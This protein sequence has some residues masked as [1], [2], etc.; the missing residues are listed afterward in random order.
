MDVSA[1]WRPSALAVVSIV[2]PFLAGGIGYLVH[3]LPEYRLA[4]FAA[5]SFLGGL[6]AVV[7]LAQNRRPLYAPLLGLV[8]NV[9]G[10]W[11]GLVLLAMSGGGWT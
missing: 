3:G 5:G 1:K 9:P 6:C 4:V 11:L 2:A 7:L 10:C 8:L